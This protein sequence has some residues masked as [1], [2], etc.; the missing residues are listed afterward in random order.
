M[1][2]GESQIY[3]LVL[4]RVVGH[5]REQR[6][7]SQQQLAAAAGLTQPTLSRIERG[8]VLPDAFTLRQLAGA[9]GMTSAEL[10]QRI[11]RALEQTAQVARSSAPAA[12]QKKSAS[13]LPWWQVAVAAAGAAGLAGLVAF[14]VGSALDGGKKPRA[15]GGAP[16][17]PAPPP[18][19][20]PAQL[21]PTRTPR[22]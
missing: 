5:L 18:G 22:R 20:P 2:A 8:Q 1:A 19:R 3:A 11:D 15:P 17:R 21:P 4:G 6:A 16:P 13:T 10:T 7:W 9:F 12:P 14:A